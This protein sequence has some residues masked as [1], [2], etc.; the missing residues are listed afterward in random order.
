MKKIVLFLLV[1]F[2]CSSNKSLDKLSDNERTMFYIDIDIRSETNHPIFMAGLMK[3]LDFRK[4]SKNDDDSFIKTFYKV[5][6]FTPDFL[7]YDDVVNQCQKLNEMKSGQHLMTLISNKSREIRIVLKNGSNVF[8]NITEV[9]GSFLEC[10][11]DIIE[12]PSLSNNINANELEEINKLTLPVHITWL[13]KPKR[14][15]IEGV[16]NQIG[17]MV[18]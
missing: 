18:N 10:N 1:I 5:A 7:V 11:K 13:K 2:S 8:I 3:N 4:I 17:S 6:D 15:L 12:I 9:T 16:M 14:K